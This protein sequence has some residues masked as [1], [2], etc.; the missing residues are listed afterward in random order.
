[1]KDAKRLAGGH[2]S[3]L[4]KFAPEMSGSYPLL[5]DS[6]ATHPPHPPPP[7]F[8]FHLKNVSSF[9]WENIRE[10]VQIVFHSASMICLLKLPTFSY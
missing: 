2:E 3:V 4:V 9:T 5:G 1:M 6:L 8:R 7:Q 10:T